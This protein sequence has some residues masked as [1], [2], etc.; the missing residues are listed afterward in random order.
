MTKVRMEIYGKHLTGLFYATG[1]I[2]TG[3]FHS[4]EAIGLFLLCALFGAVMLHEYNAHEY[5]ALMKKI[6]GMYGFCIAGLSAAAF[7]YFYLN[8]LVSAVGIATSFTIP[9]MIQTVILNQPTPQDS[10]IA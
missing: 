7:A 10:D 9:S 3:H 2:I 4:L 6:R 5:N 1:M 8:D